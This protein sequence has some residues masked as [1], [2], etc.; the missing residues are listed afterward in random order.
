[1]ISVAI[2]SRAQ[3]GINFIIVSGEPRPA[4]APFVEV[5]KQS[6]FVGLG[7]AL[8]AEEALATQELHVLHSTTDAN[9][10]AVASSKLPVASS[11]LYIF[12]GMSAGNAA[13]SRMCRRTLKSAF[14]RTL[15]GKGSG[16]RDMA[17]AEG[18]GILGE[19]YRV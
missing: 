10:C 19:G 14:S 4:V 5:R 18:V 2:P 8:A 12:S 17:F 16:S 11:Q 13:S 9:Q 6:F 3:T 7:L 15:L 1:M